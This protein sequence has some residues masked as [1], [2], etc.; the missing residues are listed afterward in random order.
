MQRVR[1]SPAGVGADA[2]REPACVQQVLALRQFDE[3]AAENRVLPQ[4]EKVGRGTVLDGHEVV[5]NLLD[6]IEEAAL[7][8]FGKSAG[9][10]DHDALRWS[11][12]RRVFLDH[13]LEERTRLVLAKEGLL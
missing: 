6:D 10:V 11:R 9:L 2:R 12:L 13:V 5:G 4:P 7:L 8:L 1:D 3:R